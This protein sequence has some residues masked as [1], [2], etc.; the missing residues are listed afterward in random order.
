M[1]KHKLA[2]KDYR[3][4]GPAIGITANG[5]IDR[6][7]EIVD[8][9]GNIIPAYTANTLL[10]H[11]PLLGDMIIGDEGVFA[12]AYT[13]KGKIDDP[14]LSVNPLSVLAPGILKTVFE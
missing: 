11:I 5:E 4:V 9:S 14:D 7:K 12:L 10:G 2:V 8:V 3:M 13:M 1:D 6:D